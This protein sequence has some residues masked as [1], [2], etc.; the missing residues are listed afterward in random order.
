MTIEIEK[1]HPERYQVLYQKLLQATKLT[2]I[3]VVYVAKIYKNIR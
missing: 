1:M 2:S 3:K